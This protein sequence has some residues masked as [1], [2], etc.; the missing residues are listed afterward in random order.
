M[1]TIRPHAS[2]AQLAPNVKDV[3]V[4]RI[5][6]PLPA[7]YVR[8]DYHLKIF[9]TEEQEKALYARKGVKKG[10]WEKFS[11]FVPDALW[12]AE[13]RSLRDALE[14]CSTYCKWNIATL[15]AIREMIPIAIEN[16]RNER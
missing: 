9:L 8:K 15:E 1:S 11:F 10:A 4:K 12:R 13:D 7:P 5:V 6:A 16:L 2:M 3:P 14:R